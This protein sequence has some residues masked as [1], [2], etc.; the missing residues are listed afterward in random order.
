M[1]LVPDGTFFVQI[2]NFVVFLILLNVVF[3]RPV[4]R[5]IAQRRAYITG[6]TNDIENAQRDVAELRGQADAKRAVARRKGEELIAQTRAAGQTEAMA[7]QSGFSDRATEIMN[8]AHRAV[9]GEIAVARSKENEIVG[10][11]SRVLLERAIGPG[12]VQ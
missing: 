3:L 2:V 12:V 11:L 8:E 10:A 4:G 7:I 9:E 6:L 5:V 1:F